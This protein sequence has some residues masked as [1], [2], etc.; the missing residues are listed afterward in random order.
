M[1]EEQKKEVLDQ[2]KNLNV[3]E[4]DAVAGGD[5]CACFLGGGGHPSENSLACACVGGGGGEYNEKGEQ[6]NGKKC[7]C[8]CPVAGLGVD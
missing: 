8:A 4:L 2:E 1:S 7:R 3:D 6:E 5:T